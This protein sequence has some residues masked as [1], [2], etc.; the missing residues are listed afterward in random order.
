MPGL[1]GTPNDATPAPVRAE[2]RRPSLR[3]RRRVA[4]P[5]MFFLL[6]TL[7][8][9]TLAPPASAAVDLNDAQEMFN[10]GKYEECI[11]EC[12]EATE[13]DQRDREA[14]WL[15]KVRAEMAVGQYAEALATLEAALERFPADAPLR[16]IAFD[17]YRANGQPEEAQASLTSLRDAASREPWR[18]GD[19]TSAVALG[20]SLLLG[21]ADAR[22]V[23]E[24]FFDAAKKEEPDA[25]APHV[26]SGELALD[27]HDYALAAESF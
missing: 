21:G 14:W 8:S 27:K 9:L 4:P 13:N 25:V 5:A 23:L 20:Q 3:L 2:G 15:L 22:Q 26:A 19:V 6:S 11:V 24:Y 1:C 18:F 7:L 12:A 16:L 10:S 17:V